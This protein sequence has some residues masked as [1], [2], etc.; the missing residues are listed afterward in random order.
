MG[1]TDFAA[2]VGSTKNVAGCALWQ[3]DRRPSHAMQRQLAVVLGVVSLVKV[4]RNAAGRAQHVAAADRPRESL[5]LLS[6]LRVKSSREHP[7]ASTSRS[8][9]RKPTDTAIQV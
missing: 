8:T 7:S 9:V 1:V 3:S 5:P 2:A 6:R 4:T